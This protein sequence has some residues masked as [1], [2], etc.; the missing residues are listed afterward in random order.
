MDL[1]GEDAAPPRPEWL[2]HHVIITSE[3]SQSTFHCNQNLCA[4]VSWWSKK[5][6]ITALSSTE[7]E[8]VAMCHVN[9]EV[10]WINSLLREMS[11]KFFTV[12]QK[13]LVDNQGV[14]F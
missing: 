10:L 6:A 14:F 11:V 2:I 1:H 5:Q 8:Y 13:V 12:P 4:T 3:K 7:A 9:K